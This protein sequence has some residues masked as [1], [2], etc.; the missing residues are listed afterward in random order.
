MEQTTIVVS[1]GAVVPTY[2]RTGW[3]WVTQ[4]E[5]ATL[6]TPEEAERIAKRQV[7]KIERW[8]KANA[9]FGAG[10]PYCAKYVI[11]TEQV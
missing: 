7:Q 5:Q 6:F 11:S 4:R 9:E 2:W 10:A 1:T 8:K 3:G